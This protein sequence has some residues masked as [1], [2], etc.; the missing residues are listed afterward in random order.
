[1]PAIHVMLWFDTEDYITKEAEDALLAVLNML[2]SRNIKAS[3]KIVGEKA[4]KLERGSRTDIIEQLKPHEVGYHTDYHSVHPTKSEY[5]EAYGFAEGAMEFER[6]EK[7]GLDDVARITGKAS[8]C[9]GQPGYSWAP[10]AFP[11]L[12]KWGIPVYLDVHDQIT[13]HNKPFWYG[14]MLNLTDLKG[15][16]RMELNENGL[17]EG[18]RDFD[19]LYDELMQEDGGFISIFYHPCEFACTGFWDGVNFNYGHNT[20]RDQWRPAPLRPSGAMETYIEMLGS[21]L[22]YTLTKPNVTYITSEEALQMETSNRQP[23]AAADVRALASVVSSDLTYCVHN[24]YSLSASELHSLFCSYLRGD[25]LLPELLYGPEHEVESERASE[26]FLVSAVIEAI[27][28]EYPSVL[29]YKQLPDSFTV[30]GCRISPV[31]LTCTLA[32]IIANGLSEQ[33]RVELVTGRLVPIMHAKTD[34][35]WGPKWSPFPQDLKVP[36][37]IRHSQLQT[38]TLKPALF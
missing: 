19:R 15:I 3:F 11:A 23:L 33:D 5:L 17:Q 14:G 18:I 2:N 6:R 10:Q 26:S 22:D 34:E 9:Y 12:R 32:S 30:S 29:D 4:R 38:W 25:S 16:M 7:D 37:L 27:S 31:D 8:K 35:V 1:M 21:F 13:L 20:P 36:K 24:G 28:V